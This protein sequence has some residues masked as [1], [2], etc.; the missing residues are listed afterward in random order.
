MNTTGSQITNHKINPRLVFKYDYIFYPP[1]GPLFHPCTNTL[2]HNKLLYP[3]WSPLARS[4]PPASSCYLFTSPIF[5]TLISSLFLSLSIT[6]WSLTVIWSLFPNSSGMICKSTNVMDNDY[7][8][9]ILD[10][11]TA[12]TLHSIQHFLIVSIP[13]MHYLDTFCQIFGT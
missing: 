3:W 5:Q 12:V 7:G 1:V 8:G 9:I 4:W 6:N 2:T 13:N 11:G 10:L